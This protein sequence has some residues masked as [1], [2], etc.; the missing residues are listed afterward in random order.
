MK[1]LSTRI[2]A[3]LLVFVMCVGYIP[4]AK[5]DESIP[6]ESTEPTVFVEETPPI[7]QTEP[8]STEAATQPV[9]LR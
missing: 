4:A 8:S 6:Q 1:K 2:L 5:A 7:V 3:F 9:N